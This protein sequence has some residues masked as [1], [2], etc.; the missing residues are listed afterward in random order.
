ME[1]FKISTSQTLVRLLPQ[2]IVYIKAD[3]NYSD[4]VLADGT[5]HTFTFQLGYLE[6]AATQLHDN[7]FFRVGRSYLIN[8]RYVFV[9]NLTT[10]QLSFA[11]PELK[12]KIPPLTIS[13]EA[14]KLL[15]EELEQAT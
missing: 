5:S 9:L 3:G 1:Y 2:E 15:K 12:A 6:K 11:G 14:L 8:R 4:V 13:R 10:E 7:P